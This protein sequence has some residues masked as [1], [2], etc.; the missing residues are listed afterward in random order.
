MTTLAP[1]EPGNYTVEEYKTIMHAL[2]KTIPGCA[3]S[4]DI[5]VG[6]LWRNGRWIWNHAQNVWRNGGDMCYHAKY[7]PRK[8]T[9]SER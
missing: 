6:F 4:T 8:G 3:I 9:Y 1:Y 7:S 2:K 5:I